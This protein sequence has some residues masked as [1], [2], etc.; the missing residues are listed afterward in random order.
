M[1]QEFINNWNKLI[2]NL[3]INDENNILGY[4]E[5]VSICVVSKTNAL[6]SFK[7]DIE[8]IIFNKN[9]SVI[10]NQYNDTYNSDYKFIGLSKEEWNI[11]R[12]KF[13]NN[14]NKDYKYI[15]EEIFEENIESKDLAS[16][17]FGDDIIEIR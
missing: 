14:K 10:E 4:I 7:N 13:I 2:S 15:S 16:D 11:E 1:K 5:S 17:I 8:T 3:K 12:D 9:I 6:F